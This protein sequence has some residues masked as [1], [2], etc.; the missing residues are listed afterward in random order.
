M[1]NK[2]TSSLKPTID[3]LHEV[4]T[5]LELK[6]EPFEVYKAANIEEIEEFWSVLLL[7]DA[8]LSIDDTTKQLVAKKPDLCAFLKHCCQS[9]HYSFQIKKCGMPSCTICRPVRM[10]MNVFSTLHFLPDPIPDN[11][12]HYKTLIDVYGQKENR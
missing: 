11:N 3:L 1:R 10:C 6:G 5:R 8:T 9:R 7:I 12:G 4:I 2:L